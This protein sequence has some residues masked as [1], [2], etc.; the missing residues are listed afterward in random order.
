VNGDALR[1]YVPGNYHGKIT[2]FKSSYHGRGVHYGWEELTDGGVE[3][4]EVPGTHRGILQQ[5][6]VAILA[7]QFQKCI[8]NSHLS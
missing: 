2:L 6:N 4:F 7:E 8:D 1:K 5:P 3:I